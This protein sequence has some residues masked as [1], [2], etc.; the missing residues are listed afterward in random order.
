MVGAFQFILNYITLKCVF[1]GKCFLNISVKF[2]GW[3][4]DCVPKDGPFCDG[5]V[6][7]Y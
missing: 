2:L 7:L 3:C 6:A 5:T 4:Y 1:M